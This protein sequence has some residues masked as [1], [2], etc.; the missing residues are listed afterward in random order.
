[1]PNVDVPSDADGSI[2]SEPASTEASSLRMS[3]NMFSATITSNDAGR[4]IRY[5]AQASTSACSSSTS[6]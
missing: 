4:V 1:M 6:G 3:P 5:I 2:P